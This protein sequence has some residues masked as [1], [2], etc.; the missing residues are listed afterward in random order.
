MS[1][2]WLAATGSVAAVLG[3]STALP[4]VWRLHRS[5][6][7][8]GLSVPSVV[9][10]VLAAG[11][12]LGYG[13]LQAD[14][15]QVLANVPGLAG[16]LAV[17]A[18]VVRRTDRRAAP[19]L[20]VVAAWTALTGLAWLVA[21]TAAVGAAAT[22]VSLVARGPQVV[23]AYRASS[24]AAVSPTSFGLSVASATL[25]AV[26]GLGTGQAPVWVCSVAV[27]LMSAAVWGRAVTVSGR[28]VP[29]PA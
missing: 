16:A 12:W 19:L 14:P 7:A 26:Y 11:T 23:V 1:S 24:L 20:A 6:N 17:A 3:V 15:P 5:P 2:A 8:D 22:V 28:A 27:A 18:L 13:T 21:G 10:G 29:V 25:W 9:L 4:Q